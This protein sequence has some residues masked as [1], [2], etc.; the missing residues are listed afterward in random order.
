MVMSCKTIVSPVAH[1]ASPF[2]KMGIEGDLFKNLPLTLF[3]KEAGPDMLRLASPV[4]L[5]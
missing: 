3:F 5:K 2:G 1:I 4:I